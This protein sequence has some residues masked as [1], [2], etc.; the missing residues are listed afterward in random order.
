MKNHAA[1]EAA[2]SLRTGVTGIPYKVNDLTNYTADIVRA[3]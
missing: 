1:A 3:M 2:N